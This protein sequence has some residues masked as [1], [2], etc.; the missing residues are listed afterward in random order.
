MEAGEACFLELVELFP[1]QEA[2]RKANRKLRLFFQA[3][4]RF[5]NLFHVAV[6][7]RTAR[8]HDGVTRDA[9][10]FFLLGV[11]DNLVGAE[12]LVFGGAGVVVA[13]LGAVLAV[14]GAAA[15]AGVHDGTKIKVV[16]VELFA[17]FVCG[18][19]EFVEVF[20]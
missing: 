8:S 6:R 3:T 14:F 16:A 17:D 5:A 4:E 2:C 15:A 12:Q 13:A 20:A 9:C 11:G 10:R 1:V 18:F 7:K 19:R